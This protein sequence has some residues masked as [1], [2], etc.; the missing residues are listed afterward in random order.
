MIK[1]QVMKVK[2]IIK[3]AAVTEDDLVTWEPN[4]L[5]QSDEVVN[6]Y[7]KKMSCIVSNAA[8]CC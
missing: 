8:A 3:E 5:I 1:V 7:F 4:Y 2:D 6:V